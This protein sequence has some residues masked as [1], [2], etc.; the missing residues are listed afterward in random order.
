M[1]LDLTGGDGAMVRSVAPGAAAEDQTGS[2]AVIPLLTRWGLSAEAD[3]VFRAMAQYG[4]RE[5]D[6]LAGLLDLPGR[7]V[8]VALDELAATGAVDRVDA[9][10]RETWRARPL[11]DVLARLGRHAASAAR[12]RVV[13]RLSTLA[14][15]GVDCAVPPGDLSAVR[16]LRGAARVRARLTDLM[17]EARVEYLSMQPERTFTPEALRSATPHD[18][19]LVDRD[20]SVLSLG[21]PPATED[22]TAAHTRELVGRGLRYRERPA[23]PTK[24]VVVDRR[25]ALVPLDPLEPTAG[26]LEL[27]APGTVQGLIAV[28]NQQWESSAV[29]PVGGPGHPSLSARERSVLRLLAAGLTDAA[30]AERL[31]LS[32]RTVA[33]TVRGLMEHYGAQNRFQLGLLLGAA[34]IAPPESAMD[35]EGA[36]HTNDDGGCRESS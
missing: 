5:P 7:R 20:L 22:E 29:L 28:F 24:L 33:Y 23:L 25:V 17:A 14:D 21:V 26:A 30:V 3:L 4:S 13:R 1:S 6:H 36:G 2:G 15:L 8:R 19:A 27:S 12:Q 9:A 11:P 35:L 10:S 18:R 31:D 32:V 16:V 34:G